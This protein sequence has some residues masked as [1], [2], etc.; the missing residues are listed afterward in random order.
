MKTT[1]LPGQFKAASVDAR[2]HRALGQP[3]FVCDLLVRELLQV[4]QHDRLAKRGWQ[5][6]QGQADTFAQVDLLELPVRAALDA[7]RSPAAPRF[8][9]LRVSA[10]SVGGQIRR[11]FYPHAEGSPNHQYKVSFW[12]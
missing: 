8:P 2:F 10:L 4:P 6:G 9:T 5:L 11:V 3:Q 12:F 7:A 1:K